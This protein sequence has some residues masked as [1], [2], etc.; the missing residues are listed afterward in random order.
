M[1]A[2]RCSAHVRSVQGTVCAAAHAP[3]RAPLRRGC[4]ISRKQTLRVCA[5]HF[6]V[7]VHVLTPLLL[8]TNKPNQLQR[9]DGILEHMEGLLGRFQS[10]LGT[11]SDEIRTLQVRGA[12]GG[13]Q[14]QGTHAR[15]WELP[16]RLS[17]RPRKD[18]RPSCVFLLMSA[19]SLTLPLTPTGPVSCDVHQAAQQA[20]G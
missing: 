15:R 18:V 5:C 7:R 14:Q 4:A 16:R 12:H 2:V 8:S 11:V 20:C 3:W 10:D 17:S 1:T 9:C 13:Q 19:C 6:H